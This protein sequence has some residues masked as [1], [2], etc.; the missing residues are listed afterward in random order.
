MARVWGAWRSVW[1]LL[2]LLRGRYAPGAGA[3]RLWRCVGNGEEGTPGVLRAQLQC[4]EGCCVLFPIGWK[5]V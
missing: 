3:V 5:G 2:Y 1:G 4:V